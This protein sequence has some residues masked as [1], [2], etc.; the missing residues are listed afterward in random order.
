MINHSHWP[1][2]ALA[3]DAVL[4]VLEKPKTASRAKGLLGGYEKARANDF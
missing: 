3:L 1:G 2:V 4:G